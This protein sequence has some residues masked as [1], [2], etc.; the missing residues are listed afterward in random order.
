MHLETEFGERFLRIHCNCLVAR[1]AVGG[2]ERVGDEGD[3][4]A[5]WQV[6]LNAAAERLPVS[7][8]QWPQLKALL[9]LRA[10]GRWPDP[11]RG[12]GTDDI[13]PSPDLGSVDADTRAA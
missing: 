9:R 13:A 11:A 5:R 1:D 6:M 10:E 2:V 12:D 3:A 8:R 4:E 7:R